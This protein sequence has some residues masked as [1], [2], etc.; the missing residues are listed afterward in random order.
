MGLSKYDPLRRYLEQRATEHVPMAFADVERVLGFPLPRSAKGPS[1]WSNNPG[2]HV[3]VRAWRDAGYKASRVDVTSEKL[4]FVRERRGT[5]T[6]SP[7]EDTLTVRLN[8]LSSAARKLLDDYTAEASG[9]RAAAV[10]RALHEA[11]I[12]RRA[13]LIDAIP[14]TGVRSDIDSVDLIREDRDAR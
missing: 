6:S 5:E 12:A 7:P 13:R 14:L 10:R 2:T 9:D 1:W 11:A 8:D 4:V 3:G